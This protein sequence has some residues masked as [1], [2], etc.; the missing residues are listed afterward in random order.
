MLEDFAFRY[1]FE[2]LT[3]PEVRT[4]N[5]LL[6]MSGDQL[7]FAGWIDPAPESPATPGET[8]LR[9]NGIQARER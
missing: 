5:M 9:L 3:V 1:Y 6:R 4:R 7:E 2:G 8:V